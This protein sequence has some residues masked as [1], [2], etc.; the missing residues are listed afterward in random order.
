MELND[1]NTFARYQIAFA[2]RMD[3]LDGMGYSCHFSYSLFLLFFLA[4]SAKHCLFLV[5]FLFLFL[6][7]L[8]L[9]FCFAGHGHE[10]SSI[11]KR[12]T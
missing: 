1:I 7:L 3:S 6:L 5:L 10:S 8:L 11:F 9:F 2:C 12:R 4:L